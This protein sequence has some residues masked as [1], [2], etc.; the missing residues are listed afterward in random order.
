MTIQDWLTLRTFNHHQFSDLNHLVHLKQQH[1][2]TISLCLPTLNEAK[3]IG[4]IVR[5]LSRTLQK[6]YPL[7]DE[8]LVIDSGSR[9]ET[10]SIARKA[11]ARVY[12]AADILPEN[13]SIRGKGEN[14]WKSLYIAQGDILVWIDTDI[15]NIHPRFVYGLLGPLLTTPE[16]GFVKGFY[17]RPLQV[18]KKLQ[19]QGGG[20][21]TEIL[22]K[23]FLN[24]F[25][26]QLAAFQQPLS[27]EYAGRR[28]LMERIPFFTGYGVETGM[29][30]DLESRFGLHR[31]AQVDLEVRVHRNQDLYALKKMA[32]GI[33]RVLFLRAE[34]QG[35]MIVLDSFKPNLLDVVKSDLLGYQLQFTEINEVERPP[36]ITIPAYQQKIGVNEEQL[37]MFQETNAQLPV[38]SIGQFLDSRLVVLNGAGTHKKE[39]LWEIS[40]LLYHQGVVPNP[41]E[42]LSQFYRR[43]FQGATGLEKGVAIP[44]AMYANVKTLKIAIYRPVQ[45]V[46]FNALDATPAT[47]I[48]AVV[49]PLSRRQQYLSVLSSLSRILRNKRFRHLL[50][51]AQT[52]REVVKILK[53]ADVLLRLNREFQEAEG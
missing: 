9:D 43:E 31:M 27:G 15:R 44:H 33:L 14:L 26:P 53:K 12:S 24:A 38:A 37:A 23:P 51:E 35:K 45:G 13:G 46:D 20:R 1:Q 29:L 34:Q 7:V 50:Q 49:A 17:R 48:V 21:V 36:M 25:F 6:K 3:T 40:N 10:V 22:V 19:P 8:I 52:P 47:L 11:G 16:I 42:L 28:Q 4:T 41:G 5:T 30:I 18:G 32:M 39:V 2:V